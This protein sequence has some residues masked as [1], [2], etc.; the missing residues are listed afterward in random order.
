ME[1]FGSN[2]QSFQSFDI[3]HIAI[4]TTGDLNQTKFFKNY[5]L[6]EA[7]L[8]EIMPAIKPYAL[9]TRDSQLE[10][11]RIIGKDHGLSIIKADIMSAA[12]EEF[13]SL[14]L[15]LVSIAPTAN[16]Y[17]I[18]PDKPDIGDAIKQTL[19]VFNYYIVELGLNVLTGKRYSIPELTFHV[20]IV[21]NKEKTDVTAFDI[22][23]NDLFKVVQIISGKIGLGITKLLKL[24]PFKLGEE[25]SELLNIDINPWK[26]S[27][28]YKRYMIDAAGIKDYKIHWKIYGTDNV[29]SF[30]PTLIMKARKSVNE[31]KAKVWCTY[32]FKS[33]IFDIFPEIKT[34]KKEIQILPM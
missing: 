4:P 13:P 16:V 8:P 5:N 18:P 24:I 34:D 11:F 21:C 32:K 19:S 25:V 30:N 20:E 17:S 7:L 6:N 15:F 29:Q 10:T 12:T 14:D 33:T 23:P 27:W 1:T 2:F 31:I 3:A 22:A 26:F 9:K 28:G